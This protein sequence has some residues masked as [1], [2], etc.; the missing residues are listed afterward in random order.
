VGEIAGSKEVSLTPT[1]NR[2]RLLYP[3]PNLQ[4]FS[5]PKTGFEG[6]LRAWSIMFQGLFLAKQLH[7]I[8]FFPTRKAI[9]VWQEVV[10]SEMAS[11]KA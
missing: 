4:E 6:A 1:P 3:D 9:E 10:A 2:N 11:E 8:R 7:Q 5:P